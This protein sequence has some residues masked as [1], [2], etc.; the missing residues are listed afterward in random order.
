M[1]GNKYEHTKTD[2]HQ[3]FKRD[4]Y[5]K[6]YEYWEYEYEYGISGHH[7][8]RPDVFVLVFNQFKIDPE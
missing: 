8:S 7:Y 6:E 2:V 4:H 3:R 1:S 5:G